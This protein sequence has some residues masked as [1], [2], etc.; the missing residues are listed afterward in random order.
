MPQYLMPQ[1]LR[2]Q[3]LMQS[4]TMK[5]VI[6]ASLIAA[7]AI[8]G[9]KFADADPPETQARSSISPLMQMKLEKS[10]SILEGLALE[11]YDA[12]ARNANSLRLLSLEA[13]WNVLQTEEY[14]MQSRE[15][16]R[17]TDMIADAAKEKDINRAALGY[18]GLTLRCVECHSYM[19]KHKV[20]LMKLQS[21]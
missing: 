17:A 11:D 6:V 19:R 10:K 14:A 13:G 2:P 5:Y 1:Y 18:V 9:T 7:L 15:F 16:R 12:I 20:E 3:Y 21:N 8:V 4:N